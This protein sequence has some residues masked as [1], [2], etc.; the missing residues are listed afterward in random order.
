MASATYPA[1]FTVPPS[2][3]SSKL[4]MMNRTIVANYGDGYAS[5]RGDGLNSQYAVFSGNWTNLTQAQATIWFNFLNSV[6]M[7]VWFTWVCPLDLSG[8][9]RKW[10]VTTAPDVQSPNVGGVFDL[11]VTLTQCFDPV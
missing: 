10:K 5:V 3:T 8:T 4:T 9:A 7:N 6:A 1:T 2:L 11:T